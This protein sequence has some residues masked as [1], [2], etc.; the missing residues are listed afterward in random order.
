MQKIVK[1]TPRA[2][3]GKNW[4]EDEWVPVKSRNVVKIRWGMVLSVEFKK[5]QRYQYRCV[6]RDVW[7]AL[8]NAPSHGEF[9]HDHVIGKF[10]YSSGDAP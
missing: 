9:L 1:T 3:N 6:P 7:M 5:G 8:M 4:P 10:K 2:I